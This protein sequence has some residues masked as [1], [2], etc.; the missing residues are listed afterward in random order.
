MN[1]ADEHVVMSDLKFHEW[2]SSFPIEGCGPCAKLRVKCDTRSLLPLVIPEKKQSQP[3]SVVV[4]SKKAI[5]RNMSHRHTFNRYLRSIFEQID[6]RAVTIFKDPI[7]LKSL[8]RINV[9]NYL[10]PK[11]EPDNRKSQRQL[12]SLSGE[13]S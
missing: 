5:M 13:I 1:I 10:K 11:K 7:S 4:I 8:S 9:W 12:K 2:A 6:F 3:N